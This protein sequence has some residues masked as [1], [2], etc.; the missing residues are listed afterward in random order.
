MPHRRAIPPK[1]DVLDGAVSHRWSLV[2]G[3]AT[4]LALGLYIYA[5]VSDDGKVLATGRI[6]IVR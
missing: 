3:A 1:C 6:V 5:L 4:P 2:N